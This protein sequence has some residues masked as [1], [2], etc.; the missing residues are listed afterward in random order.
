MGRQR[1]RHRPRQPHHHPPRH[2]RQGRSQSRRA[3]GVGEKR[4]RDITEAP[5][6]TLWLLEDANPGALIHVTPK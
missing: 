6:G 4:I 2:G 3:L 1:L 5:D